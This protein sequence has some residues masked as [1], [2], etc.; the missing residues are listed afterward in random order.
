MG[1][2]AAEA[3]FVFARYR[4]VKKLKPDDLFP[5]PFRRPNLLAWGAFKSEGNVAMASDAYEYRQRATHCLMLADETHDVFAKRRFEALAQ[6]WMRLASDLEMENV[7]AQVAAVRNWR[8][9]RWRL[10]RRPV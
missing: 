5:A 3:C 1:A 9:R 4:T 8:G 6:S 7:A 2:K 10:L